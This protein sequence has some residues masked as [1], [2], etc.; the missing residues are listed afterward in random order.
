[1]AVCDKNDVGASTALPDFETRFNAIHNRHSNIEQDNVA[2]TVLRLFRTP[3]GRRRFQDH[4][5]QL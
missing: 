2:G 3:A 4:M 1:M 5:R